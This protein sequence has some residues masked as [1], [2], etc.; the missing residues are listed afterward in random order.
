MFQLPVSCQVDSNLLS[1]RYRE[2]QKAVHPDRFAADDQ[3][4]QRLS[5]Q[6]A[7]HVNEA[8][9]TL[10]APLK[11]SIYL[12]QLSGKP[13]DM[14]NNTVMDTAF[15]MEQMELR[16]RVSEVRDHADPEAELEAIIEQVEESIDDY[17]SS[18]DSLWQKGDDKSLNEAE[19]IVKKMQF[20]VKLSAEL[21]QLESELLDD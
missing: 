6:Y 21:E 15:L 19:S 18:F 3:R 12:L 2:L 11:R 20:M 9:D 5:A 8:M 13:V 1:E 4:Q 16:E 10:K 7:A 14:E 17:Q